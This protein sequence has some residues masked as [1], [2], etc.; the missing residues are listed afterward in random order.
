MANHVAGTS[1]EVSRTGESHVDAPKDGKGDTMKINPNIIRVTDCNTG[2][3]HVYENTA[4]GKFLATRKHDS[5]TYSIMEV[6][7]ADE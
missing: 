5:L 1:L 2:E 3:R 6:G 4:T 7:V